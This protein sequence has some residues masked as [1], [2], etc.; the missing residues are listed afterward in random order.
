M[1]DSDARRR[2]LAK[3]HILAG[4]LGLDT[5]DANPE[6]EYRSIL[7]TIGRQ[8]SAGDLDQAGRLAVL[9]HLNQR[10]KRLHPSAPAA[11]DHGARPKFSAECE[12]LGG[13]IAALLTVQALHWNYAHGIAARMFRVKR[14]EWCRPDQLRAVV[15]ALENNRR[16]KARP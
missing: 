10:G 8:R 16:R 11:A 4:Q 7:W 2:E 3:I 12:P 13:K 5:A 14:I 6:S 1:S 9:D 15:A